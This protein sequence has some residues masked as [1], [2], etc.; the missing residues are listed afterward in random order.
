MF[1]IHSEIISGLNRIPPYVEIAGITKIIVQH[2]EV[3]RVHTPTYNIGHI[4]HVAERGFYARNGTLKYNE[5]LTST[6]PYWIVVYGQIALNIALQGWLDNQEWPRIR[7]Q[8]CKWAHGRIASW[9]WPA[10]PPVPALH[11]EYENLAIHKPLSILSFDHIS[12]QVITPVLM[13]QPANAVAFNALRNSTAG[14]NPTVGLFKGSSRPNAEYQ[15][16]TSQFAF[17]FFQD[18]D[19]LDAAKSNEVVARVGDDM[20]TTAGSSSLPGPIADIKVHQGR[21]ML[22]GDK[23]VG[24]MATSNPVVQ[25]I[26]AV[27]VRDG[28]VAEDIAVD[29]SAGKIA[30]PANAKRTKVVP[31]RTKRLPVQLEGGTVVQ[32]PSID[33][34][35]TDASDAARKEARRAR[36][37]KR[38]ELA[39]EEADDMDQDEVRRQAESDEEDN[40]A[41]DGVD[42]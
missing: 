23:A 25:K 29:A 35:S 11:P 16:A 37:R 40:Q 30:P 32:P 10:R 5:L 6:E 8:T 18:A 42:I 33:G 2:T 12:E 39:A 4:Q 34:T 38:A 27:V 15:P 1:K 19:E 21:T 36:K 26:P 20:G 14:V 41:D 9:E 17:R 22:S 3:L 24:V 13:V 7:Y 28:V 31:S